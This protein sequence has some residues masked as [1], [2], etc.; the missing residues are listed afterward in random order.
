[1]DT[2]DSP[3]QFTRRHQMESILVSGV[4]R[5]S[6]IRAR[7][8]CKGP[9]HEIKPYYATAPRVPGQARRFSHLGAA[10]KTYFASLLHATFRAVLLLHLRL[11]F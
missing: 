6:K 2:I 11:L 1:M 10:G 4:D 7:Q 8:K 3:A 9:P 5:F